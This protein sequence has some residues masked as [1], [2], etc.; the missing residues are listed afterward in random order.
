MPTCSVFPVKQVHPT[1][2]VDIFKTDKH[3]IFIQTLPTEKK[4]NYLNTITQNLKGVFVLNRNLKNADLSHGK[5]RHDLT[6][7]SLS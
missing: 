7:N 3:K 1:E 2:M 5:N 4:V 6:V